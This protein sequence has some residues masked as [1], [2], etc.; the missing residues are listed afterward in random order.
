MGNPVKHWTKPKSGDEK[1][2]R[3]V[4]EP[5]FW[6]GQQTEYCDSLLKVSLP[7]ITRTHH[8]PILAPVVIISKAARSSF[9]KLACVI[10]LE[11]SD[12]F[13]TCRNLDSLLCLQSSMWSSLWVF[14]R[15]IFFF[16]SF[17]CIHYTSAH[18]F[19]LEGLCHRSSHGSPFSSF[20][21]FQISLFQIPP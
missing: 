9:W 3:K 17:L 15:L 1:R 16:S 10:Y 13:S 5:N 11:L 18:S 4:E 14:L 21:L 20:R 12:S 7:L 8:H 6:Y 19:Y 2:L